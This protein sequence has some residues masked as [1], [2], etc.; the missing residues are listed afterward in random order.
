[1]SLAI[2]IAL[3]VISTIL[4]AFGSL[5]LKRGS[6]KFNI[7]LMHQL[8]NYKMILGTALYILSAVIFI[9]ALKF[10]DLS[11]LYPIS[12]ITYIWVSLLSVKFLKEKMNTFKWAGMA[13][14]IL[15]VL[16]VTG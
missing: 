6:V 8:K 1:M 2:G 15:G 3:T 13:L 10:G 4:G 7:N 14:L 11:V 5:N 16:L 12:S 9:F